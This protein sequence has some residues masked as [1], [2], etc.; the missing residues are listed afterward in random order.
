MAVHHRLRGAAIA[1]RQKPSTMALELMTTRVAG[2]TSRAIG[3]IGTTEMAEVTYY[4]A[5][6]FLAAED[7]I[8]AGEATE[9][10]SANRR[11]ACRGAVSQARGPRLGRVQP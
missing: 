10:F 1:V 5:L 6:P 3:R 11:D 8:A 4:V 7:G 2:W 9:C